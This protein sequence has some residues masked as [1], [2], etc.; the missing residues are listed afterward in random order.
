[1]N[2]QSHMIK[3]TN[4]T[5]MDKSSRYSNPESK[6]EKPVV[7]EGTFF[8]KV[9]DRDIN[10]EKLV[11][12]YMVAQT[13]CNPFMANNDYIKDLEIQDSFLKPQ[14]SGIMHNSQ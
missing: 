3:W 10:N 13:N 2:K 4:G 9:S 7:M 6:P 14:N 12:R 1:M 5:I 8:K 11:S